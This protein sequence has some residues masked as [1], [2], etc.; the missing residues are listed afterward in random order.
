[1]LLARKEQQVSHLV[2]IEFLREELLMLADD[3]VFSSVVVGQLAVSVHHRSCG[4][5]HCFLLSEEVC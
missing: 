2:L 1:M 3:V 4:G 5:S